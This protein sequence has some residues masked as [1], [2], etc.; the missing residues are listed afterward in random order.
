MLYT[1]ELLLTTR[2]RMRMIQYLRMR[3]EPNLL[4]EPYLK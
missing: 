1:K 3:R 4:L 2:F